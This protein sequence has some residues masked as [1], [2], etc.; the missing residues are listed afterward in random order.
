MDRRRRK[1]MERY[2]ARAEAKARAAVDRLDPQSWFDLWHTHV[3]WNGR[4]HS[5]AEHRQMVNAVAVR[6]LCYLETRLAHR[7]A[8]V[9]L[10]ADLSSDTMDTGIYAHSAN[11]NG[12]TFPATF[13]NL[14]WQQALP[15]EVAAILPATHWAGTASCDGSTWYVVQRQPDAAGTGGR[16]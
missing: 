4:G 5:S 10:W 16:Q 2:W 12:T 15:R 11:P 13:P 3:D 8:A 9:Q 7:G 6:V 1:R 14:D